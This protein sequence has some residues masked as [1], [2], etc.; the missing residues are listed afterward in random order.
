M[1]IC[2]YS[3][4]KLCTMGNHRHWD[5]CTHSVYSYWTIHMASPFKK[6]S[7]FETQHCKYNDNEDEIRAKTVTGPMTA[8]KRKEN[9]VFGTRHYQAAL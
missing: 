7:N 9:N 8:C 2:A 3:S 1:H 6:C 4:L 5:L